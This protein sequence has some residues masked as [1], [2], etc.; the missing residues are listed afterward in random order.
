ML[1]TS[2]THGGLVVFPAVEPPPGGKQ[3]ARTRACNVAGGATQGTP[4]ARART[5]RQS[6]G[7]NGTRRGVGRNTKKLPCWRA[8]EGFQQRAAMGATRSASAGSPLQREPRA[9]FQA[10][11]RQPFCRPG[12]EELAD[13]APATQRLRVQVRVGGRKHDQ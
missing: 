6:E 1:A 12:G 7:S 8:A 13:G 4:T 3:S 2:S 9:A 10:Q 5:L 11:S